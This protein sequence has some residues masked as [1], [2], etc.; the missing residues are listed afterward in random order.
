MKCRV[1]YCKEQQLPPGNVNGP[2]GVPL[3]FCS[4]H[5][6]EL[7]H[8]PEWVRVNHLVASDTSNMAI[9][10]CAVADFARRVHAIH[11]NYKEVK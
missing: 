2:V 7:Q 4:A 8:A 5:S 9:A 6:T 1:V 10:N 11:E 3:P